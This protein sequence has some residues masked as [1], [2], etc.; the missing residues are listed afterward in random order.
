MAVK[1]EAVLPWVMW[2][3]IPA[4][5]SGDTG[6]MACRL[7]KPL[8]VRLFVKPG[9]QAGELTAFESADLCNCA[10]QALPGRTH[11]RAWQGPAAQRLAC[12]RLVVKAEPL[13]LIR[14]GWATTSRG[15][16]GRRCISA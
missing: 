2:K 6:T 14:P 12:G 3:A 13:Q 8:T 4:T 7:N 9:L 1:A 16:C 11:G 10:V 5:A 15:S